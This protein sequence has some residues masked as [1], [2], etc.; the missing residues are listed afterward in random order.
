MALEGPADST[1]ALPLRVAGP[2]PMRKETKLINIGPSLLVTYITGD[3]QMPSS[4][5]TLEI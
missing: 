3:P 5:I 4:Q 1:I 2:P